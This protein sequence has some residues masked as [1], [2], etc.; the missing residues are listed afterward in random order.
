MA[1]RSG[2][3]FPVLDLWCALTLQRC[4]GRSQMLENQ[5]FQL[6]AAFIW[7]QKL[8]LQHSPEAH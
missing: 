4:L 5:A 2:F 3:Q 6:T 1:L 7:S 8:H